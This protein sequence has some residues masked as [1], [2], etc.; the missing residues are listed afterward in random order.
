VEVKSFVGNSPLTA[1]HVAVGQYLNYQLVLKEKQIDYTL[2]L[3]IPKS[4]YETFFMTQFGQLAI[5]EHG[6]RLII[7]DEDEE[8][9]TQW[10][11]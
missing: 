1:F 4:I 3:A 10:I 5:K 11:R 8:V 9:I 6:L 2:F 7:V